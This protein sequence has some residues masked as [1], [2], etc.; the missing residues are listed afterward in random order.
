LGLHDGLIQGPEPRRRAGAPR[1]GRTGCKGRDEID[2][3]GNLRFRPAPAGAPPSRNN[4]G[5]RLP[6]AACSL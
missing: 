4:F 6:P 5:G 3:A 1:G 2:P